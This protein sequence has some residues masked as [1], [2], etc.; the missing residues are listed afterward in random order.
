M[1]EPSEPTP[2][3]RHGRADRVGSS[4]RPIVKRRSRHDLV[5]WIAFGLLVVPAL[6]VVSRTTTSTGHDAQRNGTR[7]PVG[8]RSRHVLSTPHQATAPQ[9]HKSVV[10]DKNRHEPKSASTGTTTSTTSPLATTT[11]TT[12]VAP[13]TT[14]E[15]PTPTSTPAVLNYSGVLRYPNDVATSIPFSSA[16]GVAATRITW[17]GG[18]EL[19][20]SLRCRG[21][22]DSAPGTH[23]ISISIDGAPGACVVEVALGPRIRSKVRYAITVL[24]SN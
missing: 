5:A 3:P 20:A 11:T 6:A 16:T 22:H 2:A 21:A 18:E 15:P 17:S 23:G 1:T 9:G 19:V 7:L 4:G 24:A 12:L 14:T 13:P 10:V 8:D